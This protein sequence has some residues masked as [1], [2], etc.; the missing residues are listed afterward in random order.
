[1]VPRLGCQNREFCP[2]LLCER[3]LSSVDAQVAAP[4]D[5]QTAYYARAGPGRSAGWWPGV[6]VLRLG[7]EFRGALDLLKNGRGELPTWLHQPRTQKNGLAGRG[8]CTPLG[9]LP[10]GL[11]AHAHQSVWHDPRAM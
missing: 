3:A 10:A 5:V 4:S 9:V 6:S 2:A 8:R 1:R 11:P 7:P